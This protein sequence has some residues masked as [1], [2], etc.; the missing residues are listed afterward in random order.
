MYAWGSTIHGELGLGGVEDEQ[1]LTPRALDW[2][3]SNTV[4]AAALGDNHTLLLTNDGKVYSCGCNDYGQLG[5]DQPR[6]RPRM[7]LFSMCHFAFV[8]IFNTNNNT[9]SANIFIRHINAF[10][11][12]ALYTFSQIFPLICC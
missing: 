11:C 6:K 9:L 3:L 2:Y 1:I 10:L 12:L 4:I 8:Y 7:S 5:H